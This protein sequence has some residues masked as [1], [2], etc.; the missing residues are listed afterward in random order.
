LLAAAGL[1]CGGSFGQGA[2]IPRI[3]VITW[4]PH[5]DAFKKAF[6]DGLREYGWEEGR[7]LQIDWRAADARADRVDM[8]V[9]EL[10]AL[11]VDLIVAEFTPVAVAARKATATIPIVMAPAGDPVSTGLVSSLARP[12][13]NVTGLSN[14]A[15]EL[16]GKR[17][18]LL[19]QAVPALARVGLLVNG[20]DP[21]DR[22]FVE[23]TQQ[24][25][26]AA[27]LQLQLA[28]MPNSADLERAFA[29]LR[30]ARVTAA[31]VPGNLPVEPARVA[32]VA[33]R[34]RLPTIGVI[35]S[36]PVHG[37]LMA[38][39][40]SLAALR[41]RAADYVDRLLRGAKAQDLPVEQP[42]RFEL[43]LNGRTAHA[44]GMEL[45]QSLM[46]RADEVIG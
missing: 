3:G 32:E 5:P 40:P 39:A 29:L 30:S 10:V 14:V 19:Q 21:I 13:G 46:L 33:L 37:G 12:G 25:A 26:A 6:L 31:I 1:A 11:K 7:N 35:S 38:Y 36:W 4:L 27:R 2:R 15:A 23:S 9:A 8:L 18:E 41:R 22:S 45:P 16:A 43:V 24:A 17:L 42:T 34:D 28:E 20:R 44:L